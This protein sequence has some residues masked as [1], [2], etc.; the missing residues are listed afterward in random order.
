MPCLGENT[1][2]KR[3]QLMEDAGLSVIGQ[4]LYGNTND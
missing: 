1:G 4:M 3:K 2:T